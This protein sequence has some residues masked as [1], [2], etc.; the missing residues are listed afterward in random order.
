MT[1]ALL[2]LD[3]LVVSSLLVIQI[4]QTF[5]VAS[6]PGL[7]L[8]PTGRG[9]T[10]NHCLVS[11]LAVR[12]SSEVELCIADPCSTT[13]LIKLDLQIAITL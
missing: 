8:G 9:H 12:T 2:G 10:W 5:L 1:V 3:D 11:K 13:E 4:I 6:R 7:L